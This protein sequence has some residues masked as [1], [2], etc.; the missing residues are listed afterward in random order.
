MKTKNLLIISCMLAVMGI[1]NLEAN[2]QTVGC[3]TSFTFAPTGFLNGI[4]FNSTTSTLSCT[5]YQWDFGDGTTDNSIDPVHTYSIPG[6]YNVCL[7]VTTSFDSC[8]TL[9]TSTNCQNINVGGSTACSANFNL[10]PDSITPHSY[11]AT[12]MSTGAQPL[13]YV[14]SWGDS[15]YDYTAFPTHTYASAGYYDICLTITDATGC[16]STLCNSFQL[17]RGANSNSILSVTVLSSATTINENSTLNSLTMF[18]NP[19]N[20]KSS[21]SYILNTAS[22]VGLSIYNMSGKKMHE[23]LSEAQS[24]GKHSHN[25]NFT[26]LPEG[27]YIL[28]INVDNEITTYK[29]TVIH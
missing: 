22:D 14:W 8:I 24:A 18:P 10:Y 27:N 20:N 3:R 29:F 23:E 17:Q 5:S 2:G 1:L 13:S 9:C 26:L 15:T 21:I 4:Q 6:V 11:W 28:K 16:T 25:F 12:N 7:I 19:T